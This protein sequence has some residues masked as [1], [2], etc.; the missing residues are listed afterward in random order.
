MKLHSVIFFFFPRPPYKEVEGITHFFVEMNKVPE[1]IDL[2]NFAAHQIPCL[3]PVFLND[4]L[5]KDPLPNEMD[6]CIPEYNEILV[7]MR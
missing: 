7:D 3:P 6:H 2:A 4:Y 1:K 5:I